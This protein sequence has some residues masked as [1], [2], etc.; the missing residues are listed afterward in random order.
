VTP[1]EDEVELSPEDA[2]RLG[3]LLAGALGASHAASTTVTIP[4][5]KYWRFPGGQ[6]VD[7]P[8]STV[9]TP[10]PI[11]KEETLWET[12]E[13]ARAWVF[14]ARD[15][16]KLTA[17][18]IASDGFFHFGSSLKEWS[19]LWSDASAPYADGY[20]WAKDLQAAGKD[21]II[22]GYKN[23]MASITD[24]NAKL[25]KE[26]ILKT[27]AKR[28]GDTP[29]VVG[30]FSMG[31]LITRYTLALMENEQEDP[32]I[33]G[34]DHETSTYFSYDS[35]HRG[36]WVPVS[37]QA[38]A[39]F[40]K[41]QG[42]G[43]LSNMLNSDASRQ[44]AAY[45]ISTHTDNPVPGPHAERTKFLAD[46]AAVGS[47][48]KGSA[49]RP[50][51]KIGVANGL[52]NGATRELPAD[53]VTLTVNIQSLRIEATLYGQKP[54]P[55]HVVAKVKRLNETIVKTNGIPALDGAPGGTLATNQIAADLINE[56]FAD[57][58]STKFPWVCFVPS[59]SAVDFADPET[60][61]TV[62]IPYKPPAACGLDAYKC[63]TAPAPPS[64]DPKPHPHKHTLLTKELCT[65]LLANFE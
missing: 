7:V 21:L 15:D 1:P 19:V 22:L 51:K 50:I 52:A 13:Q 64:D 29:L 4:P 31:G 32:E 45:H 12:G 55:N 62:R 3:T 8:D 42:I 24:V 53:N 6:E 40:L 16:K 2:E 30:G 23:R 5:H 34:P 63:A 43:A 36:G 37:I 61:A 60:S 9:V 28:D 26:C 57:A 10:G 11:T 38:F 39:H 41:V 49:D 58:A 35:P 46:L 20:P 56:T 59:V 18:V 47:F 27:I 65:W 44:M 14:S 54:D 33:K 25:A 17:P 48:P